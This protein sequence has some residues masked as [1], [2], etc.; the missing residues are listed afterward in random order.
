MSVS[1]ARPSVVVAW[2]LSFDACRAWRAG[3]SNAHRRI[4][5]RRFTHLPT[6]LAIYTRQLLGKHRQPVGIVSLD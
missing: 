3:D 5:M 2:L 4:A 6:R 1:L